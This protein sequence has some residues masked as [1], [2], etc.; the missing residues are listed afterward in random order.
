MIIGLI[1]GLIVGCLIGYVI[2]TVLAIGNI[3]DLYADNMALTEALKKYR[4]KENKEGT[5]EL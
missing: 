5:W 1:I 2:G 4:S 3:D